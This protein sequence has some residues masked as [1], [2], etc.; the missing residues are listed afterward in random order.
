ML[1]YACYK[2]V[3]SDFYYWILVVC[4]QQCSRWGSN[5]K[6]LEKKRK[7]KKTWEGYI[8]FLASFFRLMKSSDI[9]SSFFFFSSLDYEK[10]KNQNLK[11]KSVCINWKIFTKKR[12]IFFPFLHFFFLVKQKQN[13]KRNFLGGEGSFILGYFWMWFNSFSLETKFLNNS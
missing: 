5:K 11:K 4:S 12:D 9:F 10:K 1:W 7:K 8:S 3:S 2:S 6:K 13:L